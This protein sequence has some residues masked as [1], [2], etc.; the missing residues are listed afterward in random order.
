MRGIGL[1]DL[2]IIYEF[3]RYVENLRS[4]SVYNVTISIWA[5][6]THLSGYFEEL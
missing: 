1:G 2:S 4:S 5:L 6:D 3:T